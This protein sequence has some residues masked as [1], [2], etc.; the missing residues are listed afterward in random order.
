MAVAEAPENDR[1]MH[2]LG[3]EYMYRQMWDKCISTLKKHINLPSS[4]WAPERAASMRYIGIAYLEKGDFQKARCWF[5]KAIAEAPSFREPYIYMARLLYST[6]EWYGVIFMVESALNIKTRPLYYINE[7]WAWGAEPYDLA[8]AAYFRLGKY[9]KSLEYCNKAIETAPSNELL[10]KNKIIIEGA[11]KEM[12]E[13][14]KE[15]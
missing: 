12:E 11:M 6:E 4:K 2:Y 8:S 7:P 10:Q 15:S 5:Y 3:R 13:F 14:Y 9:D 1:N